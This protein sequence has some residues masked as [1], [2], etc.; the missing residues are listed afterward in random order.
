GLSV[1]PL[2]IQPAVRMLMSDTTKII[3][4]PRQG[5]RWVDL[6]LAAVAGGLVTLLLIGVMFTGGFSRFAGATASPSPSASVSPSPTNT[7]QVRTAAPTTEA[8]S[9]T[10]SPTPTAA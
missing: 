8:P 10:P 5:P 2:G 3:P 6:I 1:S 9:T 4:P 7:I